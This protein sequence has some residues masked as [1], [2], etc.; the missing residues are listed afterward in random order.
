LKDGFITYT[1]SAGGTWIAWHTESKPPANATGR[2]LMAGPGPVCFAIGS[3][4]DEALAKL[5]A[6]HAI[7]PL[8]G[9]LR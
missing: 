3:T 6:E 5:R 1:T 2:D 4:A 9:R 7:H 8:Y